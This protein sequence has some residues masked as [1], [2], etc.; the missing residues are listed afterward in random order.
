MST[1]GTAHERV[2]ASAR[3]SAKKTD[4]CQVSAT[5]LSVSVLTVTRAG[6]VVKNDQGRT[7]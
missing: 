5:P 1:I 3:K 2:V 4:R 6:S 7:M